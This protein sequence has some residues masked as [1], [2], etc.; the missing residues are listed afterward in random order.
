MDSTSLPSDSNSCIVSLDVGSS[1]VRALL[2]DAQ[3]RQ[4]AGYGAQLAYEVE[5]T[6][7]G[8][9]E[10]NPDKL[11]ELTIACLDQLHQQVYSAGL[12]I[13]AVGGSAF[14]HSFLGVD[15]SGR[16]VIPILHLLDTRANEEAKQLADGHART[17][18]VPHSSYWPAKL[19]W[20]EK[21]RPAE[22]A[23]TRQWL[24]FPEY[25]FQKL[26]GR[27]GASTSMAS[28]S[29][30]WNQN[31]NEYDVETLAELPVDAARL[32]DPA[33][34]DAA[35]D[36]LLPR[37]KSKWPAFANLPWFPFLGDGACN[38]IGSGCV[39]ADRFALMVG[40]T[41]AMRAVIEAPRVD[42]PPGLWCYRVDRRRFVVGGALS[43]GGN[44]YAWLQRTLALPDDCEAR[45]KAASPGAHGV[46]FLPFLAGERSPYWRAD[47]R[48]ALTGLSL[49]TQPFDI[50]HAALE[51]IA[52][53][54]RA[55][56]EM[57]T[58]G[59]PAPAAVVASGSALLNS[60]AWIQIMADA[61]GRTIVV[62]SEPE[63]SCR[64][65]V[66]WT[67]ERIGA[68]HSLTEL[69]AATGAVFPARPAYHGVY[70]GLLQQQTSLYERLF[71]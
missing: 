58:A 20:L 10:V 64:G 42:V 55:I 36:Q 49:A 30:L 12:R 44:V 8:G 6:P 21:N 35:Q 65:A 51:S 56:H 22:F 39:G 48:G 41:G 1:S 24:S 25:L 5:T 47:L 3:A 45:L 67:L 7:D 59:F 34:M 53:R 13:A 33:D 4:I 29:G 28:G 50:L 32:A 52:L 2:F 38:N 62:C 40:T 57:L 70:D 69:P 14:W 19:L 26:F 63:A 23:A 43:N 31:R 68:I 46:A 71:L 15:A 9:A 17:G 27:G 16:P 18:C 37:Y 11:A 60:P 61:L 54:F 66:L